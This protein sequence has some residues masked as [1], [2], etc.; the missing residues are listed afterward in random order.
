MKVS[1]VEKNF[2]PERADSPRGAGKFFSTPIRDFIG[3]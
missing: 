3:H 2:I 1:D